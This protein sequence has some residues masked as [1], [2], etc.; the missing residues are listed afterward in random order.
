MVQSS[1]AEQDISRM[2][3]ELKRAMA[4]KACDR[5]ACVAAK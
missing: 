1:A 3:Q 5:Q 4:W 2:A